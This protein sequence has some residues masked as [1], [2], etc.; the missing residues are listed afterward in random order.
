MSFL[1]PGGVGTSVSTPSPP[2][3]K[4]VD[5][6]A[7]AALA[8]Q[9]QTLG[10]N[11]SDAD[12][13]ARFPGLVAMRD[14][15]I[16][17]AVNQVTGP[18]DPTVENQFASTG[19]AGALSAFGGSTGSI[20]EAGSAARGAIASSIANQTQNKQDYDWN[21]LMGLINDNPERQFG[22]TGGDLLNLA[23]G[24]TVGKNQANFAGYAAGV[25]GANAQNAAQ[26][27]AGFSNATL[28]LSI[29]GIAL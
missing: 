13:A 18:L 19:E 29:I 15:E 8:Q 26:T 3:F 16:S 6:P 21:T 9:Y 4:P 12:F 24:N 17:D 11:L 2:P 5:I 1:D 22:L 20:G 27:Q 10:Y 28:A 14:S 23:I 7:T 25:Q